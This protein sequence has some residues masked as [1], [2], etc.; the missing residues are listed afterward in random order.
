[1]VIID[2]RGGAAGAMADALGGVDY[3]SRLEDRM[4]QI[5]GRSAIATSSA[6]GA[7]HAA[8]YL[9][10]VTAGAYVFVPTYT[11]YSHIATVEHAGA[12]PVFIDCD[13]MTRCVSEAALETALVW[14]KLQ[15]KSPAAAVIADA[16]GSVADYDK[17][18]PLCKAFD[19]PTIEIATDAL[20]GT[21]KN[22][23]C[24]AL[25]DYG[26]MSFVKRLGGGGGVLIADARDRKAARGF[27]RAEFS[28]GENHDYKM[29]NVVAALDCALLD[30]ADKVVALCKSN[31]AA[32]CTACDSVVRPTDGDAAAYAL[33]RARADALCAAG[34]SVKR[35]PPVHTMQKYAD[36]PYFEHERGFSACR[37]FDDCCLVG[38][39]MSRLGLLRLVRIL[40]KQRR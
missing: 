17:L 40:K 31:L 15:N 1:M 12:I 13:P 29:H 27:C 35:P 14:A 37:Q 4:S 26:V 16:F 19:V 8:L 20:G 6:D 9:C 36:S 39:D 34:F 32:L 30:E 21:Y 22:K 11:F 24:G 23:P 7:L 5:T 33:V 25:A 18:V 3:V 38:T 2:R 28:Y 10:G